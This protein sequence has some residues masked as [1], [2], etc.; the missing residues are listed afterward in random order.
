MSHEMHEAPFRASSA[1]RWRVTSRPGAAI[2][3]QELDM[4][5]RG[6]RGE[7]APAAHQDGS[8]P[9]SRPAWAGDDEVWSGTTYLGR[10]ETISRPGAIIQAKVL[11]M[12]NELR[13]RLTARGVGYLPPPN[14]ERYRVSGDLRGHG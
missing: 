5:H 3:V 7:D 13:R 11:Q 9:S 2:R 10:W 4:R 8:L 12:S 1:G 6:R 14:L